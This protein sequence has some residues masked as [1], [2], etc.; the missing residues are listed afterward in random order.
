MEKAENLYNK[1]VNQAEGKYRSSCRV[2]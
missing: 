2:I 1:V